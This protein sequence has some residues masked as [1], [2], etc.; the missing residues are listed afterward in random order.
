[1]GDTTARLIHRVMAL[2]FVFMRGCGYAMTTLAAEDSPLEKFLFDLR[3]SVGGDAA[4]PARAGHRR[5][6]DPPA[7]AGHDSG[8]RR[9]TDRISQPT[10]VHVMQRRHS[11]AN[12]KRF[13][14]P[15]T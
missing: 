9:R 15:K 5:P 6:S 13:R 1:M 11:A 10:G 3:I 12:N 14:R 4:R 8:A 7:A 2:G